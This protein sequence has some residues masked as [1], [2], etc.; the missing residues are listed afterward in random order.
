MKS[1]HYEVSSDFKT[2]AIGK[3][4]RI[5]SEVGEISADTTLETPLQYVTKTLD[6]SDDPS[7]NCYTFRSFF[8]GAGL[9]CFGAVIAEIFYFKPQTVNVNVIF[10][11]IIAYVLGE[12]M[13]LIPRWGKLGRF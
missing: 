8:L 7:L 5:D 10:L 4:G 9:A 1:P 2:G 6:C 13:A 3:D 11:A 12:A